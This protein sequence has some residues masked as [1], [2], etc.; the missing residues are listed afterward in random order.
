MDE[1]RYHGDATAFVAD[2]TDDAELVDIEGTVH[3]GR[4]AVIAFSQS[5]FETV[6]TG[7]RLVRGEVPVRPWCATASAG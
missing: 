1:G 7:S 5:P 2:F 4:E 3:K 6:L